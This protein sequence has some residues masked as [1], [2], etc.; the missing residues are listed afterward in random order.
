MHGNI[1]V[2]RNMSLELLGSPVTVA[3]TDSKLLGI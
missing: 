2:S 1:L 3:S